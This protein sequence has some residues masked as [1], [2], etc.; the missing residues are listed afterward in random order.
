MSLSNQEVPNLDPELYE[1]ITD[2]D[3]KKILEE[4]LDHEEEIEMEGGTVYEFDGARDDGLWHNTSVR[5][6][7]EVRSVSDTNDAGALVMS[8][9]VHTNYIEFRLDVPD[10]AAKECTCNSCWNKFWIAP[11]STP[12]EC[13]FC[14]ERGFNVATRCVLD[15]E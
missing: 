2:G 12:G 5:S 1:P 6:E 15:G 10:G 3:Y 7:E 11:F 13:P 9:C 4:P 14:H 8:P